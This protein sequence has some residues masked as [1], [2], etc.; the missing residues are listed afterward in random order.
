MHFEQR[1]QLFAATA[2]GLAVLLASL[3]SNRAAEKDEPVAA[4][5][6]NEQRIA[7]RLVDDLILASAS[8]AAERGLALA[9]LSAVDPISNPDRETLKERWVTSDRA[10]AAVQKGARQLPST[11]LRRRIVAR[12]ESAYET[13]TFQRSEIE[14]DARSPPHQRGVHAVFRSFQIATAV[15]NGMQELLQE[16]HGELKATEPSIAGWLEIQGLSLEMAEHAGR[17][18]AQIAVFLAASG[19]AAKAELSA[20]EYNRHKVFSTW[21]QIRSTLAGLVP[22]QH[23]AAQVALVEE[24]YFVPHIQM[25]QFLLSSRSPL[26]RRSMS[27]I[28][29]FRQATL[30]ID[31]MLDFSRAAGAAATQSRPRA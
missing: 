14:Q 11:M 15:I 26:D 29:W 21:T 3:I 9:A 20:A 7:F 23:V 24:R 10:S 2:A 5:S 25:R 8:I 31:A 12:V 17:E 1:H 30:G 18:R 27:P 6:L 19:K 13:L 28:E 16:I 22:P 4:L